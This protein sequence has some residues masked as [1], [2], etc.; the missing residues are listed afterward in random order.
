MNW[1]AWSEKMPT[2]NSDP[3]DLTSWKY[4][5]S[6]VASDEGRTFE[7]LGRDQSVV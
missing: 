7:G 1:F 5:A 6:M 3:D 4:R 2:L